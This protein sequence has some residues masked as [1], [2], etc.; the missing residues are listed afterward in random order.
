MDNV[1]TKVS[2]REFLL[3]PNE[4]LKLLGDGE[5]VILKRGYPEFVVKRCCNNNVV[6]S[7]ISVV[8]NEEEIIREPVEE[9]VV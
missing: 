6:T 7:G 8:T 5:L 9:W 2:K 1:V 4:Y 3:R